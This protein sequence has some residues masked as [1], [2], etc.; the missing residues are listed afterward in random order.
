MAWGTQ[1]RRSV[2][3]VGNH[4]RRATLAASRTV[5]MTRPAYEAVK[6]GLQRLGID[7]AISDKA[8]SHY[9]GIRR[10]LGK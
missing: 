9:D 8:L 1:Y 4:V 5:D 6:P 2:Q 3:S 10:A 7:T